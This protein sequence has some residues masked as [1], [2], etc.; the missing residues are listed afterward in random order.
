MIYLKR[1][2]LKLFRMN[3][4]HGNCVSDEAEGKEEGKKNM[5]VS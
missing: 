1:K 2:L 3:D 4:E 5:H